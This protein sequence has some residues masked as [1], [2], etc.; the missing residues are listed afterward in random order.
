MKNNNAPHSAPRRV[1]FFT[2]EEDYRCAYLGA[3]GFSTRYIQGQT[4]LTPGKISYRL[5]K[6]QIKRMDYRN[7]ESEFASIVMRNL[8]GTLNITL[9]RFLKKNT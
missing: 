8:R 4:K 9:T 1:D 5:K 2:F 6:A 7:G 3:L